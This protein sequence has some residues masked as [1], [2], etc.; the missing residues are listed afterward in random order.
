MFEKFVI[1]SFFVMTIVEL[2]FLV[3][4]LQFY[5]HKSNLYFYNLMEKRLVVKSY[6]GS[7]IPISKK[8]FTENGNN[9]IDKEAIPQSLIDIETFSEITLQN[10]TER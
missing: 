6:I 3:N 9:C 10:I 2:V 1:Y 5:T 4:L 8:A 7:L